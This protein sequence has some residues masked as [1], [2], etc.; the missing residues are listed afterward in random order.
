M[1]SIFSNAEYVIVWFGTNN[2][3]DAEEVFVLICEMKMVFEEQ[4]DRLN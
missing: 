1:G 4:R 3:G 2:D